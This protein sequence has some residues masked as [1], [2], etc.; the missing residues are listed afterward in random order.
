M[1]LANFLTDVIPQVVPE[2]KGE[3]TVG[4][5]VCLNVVVHVLVVS[6][7]L[8]GLEPFSADITS[9]RQN[10][11]VETIGVPLQPDD[12]GEG[13]ITYFTQQHNLSWHMPRGCS[14]YIPNRLVL[15]MCR[16]GNCFRRG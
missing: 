10:L 1:F 7:P 4:A 2:S 15:R 8:L 13:G 14:S 9:V 11:Q 6:A 16:F 12:C 5:R 3:R